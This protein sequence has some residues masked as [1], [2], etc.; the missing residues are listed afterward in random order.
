MKNFPQ[1]FF[2]SHLWE[3]LRKMWTQLP[4]FPRAI[5]LVWQASGKWTILWAVLLVAQGFL[6]GV[7][8]FLTKTLV[9]RLVVA[10]KTGGDSDEF[11]PILM[12]AALLFIVYSLIELFRCISTWLR[13]FQSEIVQNYIHAL[14]H[15][16]ALSLDLSY[17]ETPKYH[18]QLHRARSDAI[19]RPI[20]LLENLGSLGQTT[21]T[22]IT[23]AGVLAC[24]SWWLPLILLINSI[25][26]FVVVS[27]YTYKQHAWRIR[28]TANERRVLYYDWMLTLGSAAAEIR[29]FDLGKRFKDN[30]QKINEK[31]KQ[32]RLLFVKKQ[33]FGE[34]FAGISGIGITGLLLCWM[35][36]NA[37]RGRATLGDL[38]LFMQVFSQGQQLLRTFLSSASEI[39]R[40]MLFLEN[41]FDLLDL[42]PK[43]HDPQTP[44][45]I[46]SQDISEIR[47]A[48][49]NFRY[50][51]SDRF[52]LN[53]FNISIPGKKITAIVGENG[54]G[55][56]TFLKLI[57]RFY[58]PESGE[59]T[60]DKENLKSFSLKSLRSQITALFQEPVRYNETVAD[61]I[62][63][64][65]NTEILSRMKIEEAAFAAGANI[66]ISKL[67]KKYDE[68]LGKWFGGTELS[69]GE[70]QR[71]A[72][73][74]AFLRQASLII[75][76]EPTSAMDS[77]AE[78][79]WMSKFRDLVSGKT[80]LI[81]THRFTTALKAD[82]IHVMVGGKVVESG[83][84]NELVE[85]NGLYSKSWKQQTGVFKN[86]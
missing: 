49:V 58:D 42:K 63:F 39:L 82:F 12:V 22:L 8:I 43:I 5:S 26:A 23:M 34:L 18:D 61:N 59:V 41:L 24:Y 67:P 81:I 57:C 76:D 33:S 68:M 46:F 77:W 16:K 21:I 20:A 45:E 51:G 36:W 40:N 75:L 15:E 48:E 31:L 13:A 65:A 54:A 64:A 50:P 83:N 11:R 80:A 79:D 1:A 85:L 44:I 19:S 25:P 2:S 70:W 78:A 28:N 7:G 10:L 29:L 37:F 56:S 71:L 27:Y 9:N 6:P 30:F 73:A 52:A 60:I 62:G 55:K 3:K 38:A 47:F 72:L 74:R 53:N 14:I 17:F 84:H 69:G 4:Y 35:G 86:F 32:E 66:P